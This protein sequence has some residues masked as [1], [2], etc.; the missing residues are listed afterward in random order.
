MEI[1]LQ[2]LALGTTGYENFI[3]KQ[4]SALGED[5]EENKPIPE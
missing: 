3:E 5:K 1:R 2:E 4:E